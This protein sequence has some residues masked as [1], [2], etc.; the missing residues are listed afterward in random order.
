M[1]IELHCHT[2][3]SSLCGYLEA[4]EVVKLHKENGY[5]GI[6]ITDH[7]N[8]ENIN[9]FSGNLHEKVTEWLKSYELA[10]K[11]GEE[12]GVKVF[13]GLEAR[14]TENNN[15]YLI[16]GAT[17]EFV[18]KYAELCYYSQQQLYDICEKEHVLLI[19]AHPFREGCSLA[20]IK[21][22]HGLEVINLN[23]RHDSHNKL[24]KEVTDKNP[25]LISISGSDFHRIEDVGAAPVYFNKEFVTERE[26]Y[27]ELV[28]RN[29]FSQIQ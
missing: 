1:K 6:V 27:E 2:K 8:L 24:A 25:Q 26:L 5:D 3:N 17:P 16:Y 9:A 11:A 18:K 20:N 13:F 10:K 28:N 23:P 19:Q 15:D 21:Y 29:F 12:L 22:L 4:C 14:I 7:F